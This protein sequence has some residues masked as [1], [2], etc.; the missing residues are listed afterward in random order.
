MK[1][2]LSSALAA[3]L[4]IASFLGP[5]VAMAATA[6]STKPTTSAVNPATELSSNGYRI[7]PIRTDI[8]VAAGSSQTIPITIDNLTKYGGYVKPEVD[9]FTSGS[10]ENGVPY[11]YLNGQSA[12]SHSLRSFVEPL[13]PFDLP[14]LGSVILNVTISIPKGTAAGGYYGA[15]RLLPYD[16]AT[17]KNINLTGSV[18]SLFLVT[19][20]GKVFEQLSISSFDVRKLISAPYTFSNPGWLFSKPNKLYSV[21][22]FDDTGDLQ[23]QPFGKIILK[24]GSTVLQTVSINQ[25]VPLASVLPG[26]IR[27]FSEPL[28]GVGSFGKYTVYGNFGYGSD[29]QLLSDTYSFYVIPTWVFITVGVLIV[30]L[31]VLIFVLP[32]ILRNYRRRVLKSTNRSRW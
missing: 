1:Y 14:A 17:G 10:N 8:T 13:K 18:A 20:P 25:S 32:R 28:S 5:S 29:G 2:R 12:P 3:L 15:V 23:E 4:V 19:V 27:L 30:V 6:K 26:S 24:K 21:V 31:L 9:D 11:I 16:P 7:S 22:R